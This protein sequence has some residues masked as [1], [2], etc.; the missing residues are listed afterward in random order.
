MCRSRP[1]LAT[2]EAPGVAGFGV[3]VCLLTAGDRHDHPALFVTLRTITVVIVFR[4]AAA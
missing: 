3:V 1:S 4:E 2:D